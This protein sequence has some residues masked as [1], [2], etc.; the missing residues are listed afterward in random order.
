[1][2]D[3]CTKCDAELAILCAN[4]GRL[5]AVQVR[6][7]LIDT[8]DELRDSLARFT[9]MDHTAIAA[10]RV[11]VRE[12][13]RNALPS[14]CTRCNGSGAEPPGCPESDRCERCG[15][16][17]SH[18]RLVAGEVA[19]LRERVR[20]AEA[21]VLPAEVVATIREELRVAAGRVHFTDEVGP[22]WNAIAALDA[23]YPEVA[24]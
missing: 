10:L 8:I 3:R 4:N 11:E 17:T 24:K 7:D 19:E 15:G 6:S 22:I 20:V 2:S 18:K 12:L 13:Q 9:R 14:N 16:W 1:M 21:R 23:A 5:R